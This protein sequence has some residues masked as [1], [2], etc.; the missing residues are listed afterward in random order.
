MATQVLDR[1]SLEQYLDMEEGLDDR[2]EFHDG[3]ILPMEAATPTHS[4]LCAA[5]VG[6]LRQFFFPRCA[7]YDS[8]LNLYSASANK[9]FHPDVTV[10]CG[11]PSCP[12]PSCV[13]N[14]MVLVEVTSPTTKDYDN[15]TKREY[16]FQLPSLQHYLLVSQTEKRIGHYQ[17]SGEAWLYVDR[18]VDGTLFLDE[19]EIAVEAIYSGIL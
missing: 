11:Q 10:V 16:Y 12:K 19:V 1:Y 6:I 4:S 13:D 3:L 7:V 18:E 9:V 2:S 8:S 17:R 5:I 15:G 14:P